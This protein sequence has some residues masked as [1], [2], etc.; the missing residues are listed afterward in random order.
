MKATL[1]VAL[2]W[3]K[4]LASK[5]GALDAL[6]TTLEA[7]AARKQDR[8][9]RGG[10]QF[11]QVQIERVSKHE[12]IDDVTVTVPTLDLDQ[13]QKEY[14]HYSSRLRTLDNIV[15]EANYGTKVKILSA[16]LVG[17]EDDEELGAAEAE[18]ERTLSVLLK[19]RKDIT[20]ALGP[21]SRIP[22]SKLVGIKNAPKKAM[23]GVQ[24][25]I[26][27]VEKTTAGKLMAEHFNLLKQQALVDIK[28]H[29]TNCAVEV[30][31]AKSVMVVYSAD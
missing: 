28:I 19:I 3:R 23:D 4:Q 13:V 10:S 2:M 11:T 14:K 26:D 17:W 5:V 30:D 31:V 8:H 20:D 9:G 7:D 29:E 1:D 6:K 27:S 16:A 22:E 12:G 18:V 24:D 15:Q 25:L 21:A